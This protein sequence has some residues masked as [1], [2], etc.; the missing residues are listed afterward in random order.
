MEWG[1]GLVWFCSYGSYT[2]VAR[3]QLTWFDS[4]THESQEIIIIIIFNEREKIRIKCIYKICIPIS[5]PKR[6]FLII[7]DCFRSLG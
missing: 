3:V 4:S 5:N 6:N 7:F 1:M 2:V